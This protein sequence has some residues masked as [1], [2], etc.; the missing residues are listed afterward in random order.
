MPVRILV[1]AGTTADCSLAST[2]VDCL[3]VLDLLADKG[4]DSDAIVAQAALQQ[5]SVV[6]PP[7]K[8]RSEQRAYDKA[9]YRIRHMVENTFL[10]LKRWRG[11]ATRYAKYKASGTHIRCFALWAATL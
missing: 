5:L 9:R 3:D 4:H 10:H 11:I 8:N 1:T 7:K 6:I 2:L